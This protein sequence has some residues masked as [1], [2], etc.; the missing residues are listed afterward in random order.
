[1]GREVW[2]VFC[3]S[4]EALKP[5]WD[6]RPR[7]SLVISFWWLLLEGVGGRGGFGRVGFMSILHLSIAWRSSKMAVCFLL[8]WLG[9]IQKNG[10]KSIP[11]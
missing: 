6:C 10:T 7:W 1:M 2:C 9:L 11:V 8:F 3:P 5:L 4:K